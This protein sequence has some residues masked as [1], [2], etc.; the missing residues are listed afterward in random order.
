[1]SP[2]SRSHA[3]AGKESPTPPIKECKGREVVI[4]RAQE[5]V[6]LVLG[7]EVTS[8]LS[9]FWQFG[10]SSS[11]V[12]L[13][14]L[15]LNTAW[16]CRT[17]CLQLILHALHASLFPSS[18]RCSDR[19]ATTFTTF[20]PRSKSQYWVVPMTTTSSVAHQLIAGERGWSSNKEGETLRLDG[21]IEMHGWDY[22]VR[23]HSITDPVDAVEEPLVV[24]M[25]NIESPMRCLRN[26][27]LLHKLK[28]E[29]KHNDF[30]F[31]IA[32]FY[33]AWDTHVS[34]AVA[35]ELAR[36][37]G[38]LQ[39][40]SHMMN[41]GSDG[42]MLQTMCSSLFNLSAWRHLWDTRNP[43]LQ[44]TNYLPGDHICA[45]RGLPPRL[46]YDPRAPPM[47]PSL[48]T[49]GQSGQYWGIMTEEDFVERFVYVMDYPY[50]QDTDFEAQE[51]RLQAERREARLRI[52]QE[53]R[54]RSMM[55]ISRRRKSSR[56][57]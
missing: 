26:I 42:E 41:S 40:T 39:L 50:E 46:S 22:E 19:R 51:R 47:L 10:I 16:P 28:N 3:W 44:G 1:M 34:M 15:A 13:T 56:R 49:R 35:S 14:K 18:Q 30:L 17:I 43:S 4:W 53:D 45:P 8:G 11:R 20:L 38:A 2:F 5:H 48:R 55:Y 7:F 23:I 33:R 25:L 24:F 36:E 57:N 54:L 31:V 37:V 12:P 27:C 9:R 21:R 52:E 29:S 6:G 32:P